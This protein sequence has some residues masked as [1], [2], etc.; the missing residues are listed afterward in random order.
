MNRFNKRTNKSSNSN[1]R[2]KTSLTITEGL[3]S[4]EIQIIKLI[5]G[6]YPFWR[7]QTTNILVTNH[8]A[9]AIDPL[10]VPLLIPIFF[11]SR[12]RLSPT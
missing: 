4:S 10:I 1:S 11:D 12:F 9:F 2:S 3:A 7:D 5:P 8:L 6:Q